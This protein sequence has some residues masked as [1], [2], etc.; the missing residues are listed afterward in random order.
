MAV[1]SGDAQVRERRDDNPR[2]RFFL[3]RAL[4]RPPARIEDARVYVRPVCRVI[5]DFRMRRRLF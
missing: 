5:A 3:R 2:G 1:S 4:S